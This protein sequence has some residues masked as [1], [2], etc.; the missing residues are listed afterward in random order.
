MSYRCCIYVALS[1]L[2]GLSGCSD[3]EGPAEPET[4]HDAGEVSQD[5]RDDTPIYTI[6]HSGPTAAPPDERDAGSTFE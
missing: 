3:T 6:E 2:V 4:N 1:V 5:V